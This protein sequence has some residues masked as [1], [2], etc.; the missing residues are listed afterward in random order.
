[1]CENEFSEDE[2]TFTATADLGGMVD[3]AIN[4]TVGMVGD[5]VGDGS[6]PEQEYVQEQSYV[7][8]EP[9]ELTAY[10]TEIEEEAGDVFVPTADQFQKAMARFADL[11][12]MK[13]MAK[14]LEAKYKEEMDKITEMYSDYMAL[15][16]PRIRVVANGSDEG[17]EPMFRTV[18]ISKTVHASFSESKEDLIAGM[19]ENGLAALVSET[20]NANTFSAWV[21]E[22]DPDGKLTADEL[23]ALLPEKL[24]PLVKLTTVIT[25]KSTKK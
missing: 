21:R 14:G 12:R 5:L 9:A 13:A 20:Y 1:M 23:H 24:K 7:P 8:A 6:F 10:F 16:C 25:I 17:A 22:L 11:Y 2:V 15:N 3:D 19:K 18:F 4:A